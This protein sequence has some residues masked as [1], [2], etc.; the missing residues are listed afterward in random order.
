[1]NVA[2]WIVAGL[3]AVVLLVASSAK[4]FVPRERLAPMGGAASR[5]VEDFSPDSLKAIAVLEI[6]G[7]LGL[8]LPA[9][10]NIAPVLTPLAALG[11]ALLFAGAVVMRLRRGERATI[12]GDLVYL[13]LAAFVALGRFGLESF[14]R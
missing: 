8:I 4:I 9:A 11:V 2:L 7:A 12:L 13:A 10:L 3:L 5:W 1:M 14:T 6:L